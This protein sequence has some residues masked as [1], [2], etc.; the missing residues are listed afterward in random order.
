M[1]NHVIEGVGELNESLVV[2]GHAMR[3]NVVDDVLRSELLN[4]ISLSPGFLVQKGFLNLLVL[5]SRLPGADVLYGS[6]E[7]VVEELAQIR[8]LSFVL[9]CSVDEF[10]IVVCTIGWGCL[11]AHVL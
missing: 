11:E 10:V 8:Y 3:L 9:C 5:R 1:S 2:G 7:G 6:Q 4:R